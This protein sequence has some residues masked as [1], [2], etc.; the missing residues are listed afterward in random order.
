[1]KDY[2]F[3]EPKSGAVIVIEETNKH[4][5]WKIF[6]ELVKHPLRWEVKK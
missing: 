6:A 3:E 5:A 2:V 4:A 1:M